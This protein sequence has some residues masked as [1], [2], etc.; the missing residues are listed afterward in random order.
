MLTKALRKAVETM[1]KMSKSGMGTG[2]SAA[3][4]SSFNAGKA[5]GVGVNEVSITQMSQ[6]NGAPMGPNN[7]TKSGTSVRTPYE[8]MFKGDR[9]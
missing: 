5:V 7:P 6:K 8:T 9:V 4:K 3:T 2:V 1:A